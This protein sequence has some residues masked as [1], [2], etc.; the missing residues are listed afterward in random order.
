MGQLRRR[1]LPDGYFHVTARGV[2]GADIFRVDL[3]R[4]DF[5]HLLDEAAARHGLRVFARCLMDTHYHLI[6]DAE[7]AKLSAAMHE[8]NGRYALLFNQRHGRR[9]HLFGKRFSSWVIR[10]DEHF[11]AAL[12]YLVNNP[13]QAGRSAAHNDR[14]TKVDLDQLRS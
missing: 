6:V 8:L 3:D 12:E 13:A 4:L 2:H 11:H 1:E 5:I 14:W 7:V 10:N 9:G